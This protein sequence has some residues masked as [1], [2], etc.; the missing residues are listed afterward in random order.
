MYLRQRRLSLTG[1]ILTHLHS[2]HAGGLRYLLESGIPV[3]RCYLPWGAEL[4]AAVPSVA[5]AVETLAARGTQL[6][7]LQAGDVLELPTG[8]M[9]VLWPQAEKVRRDADLNDFCLVTLWELGEARLLSMSDLPGTYEPYV[10]TPRTSL[11]WGITGRRTAPA[12]R[13]RRL[14]RRRWRWFPRGGTLDL[15]KLADRLP[16]DGA[17]LDRGLRRGDPALFR[18][19]L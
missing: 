5:E 3:E 10:A 17:V 9:Q 4:S 13:L 15:A 16:G 8:R 7:Y 11:R 18:Q 2:D 12:A 1:L 19:A 14:W 6:C